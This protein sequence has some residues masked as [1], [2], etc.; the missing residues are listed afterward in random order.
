MLVTWALALLTA[1][2]KEDANTMKIIILG[3]GRVGAALA[4]M[5]ANERHDVTVIDQ[6]SDAFARLGKDYKAKG[7]TIHTVVGDGID[8][9]VL[10]RAGLETANAF[11]AVTN[12][13]NRNIMAA[14]IAKHS[15]KV[16]RVICR[17]YDPIRQETYRE[18]G[19]ESFCPTI[20]GAHLLHNALITPDVEATSD[21]YA[22]A[23]GTSVPL[24]PLSSS[25]SSGKGQTPST[26][27]R[28]QAS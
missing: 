22:L 13:D 15:F 26:P 7:Q 19:L 2:S 18:V 24:T 6:S 3:C 9:D 27:S 21:A 14:Q 23:L 11:V 4:L 10:R 16:G 5:M 17:I 12:G 25:A 20:L 8:E 28:A 1:S